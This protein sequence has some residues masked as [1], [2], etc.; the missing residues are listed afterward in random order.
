MLTGQHKRWVLK[1]ADPQTVAQ[2][3][4]QLNISPLLARILVLRGFADS[5]SARRYLSSSLRTDLP[6]PF[7]MADME[8]AV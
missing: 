1:E 6:S 8:P 2:Q 7:E 5:G 3:S 4:E